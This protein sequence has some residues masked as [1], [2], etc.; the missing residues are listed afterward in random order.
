MIE[1]KGRSTDVEYNIKAFGRCFNE[2]ESLPV[3]SSVWFFSFPVAF[4]LWSPSPS[5]FGFLNEES[6]TITCLFFLWTEDE[7]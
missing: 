4:G 5:P 2:V 7:G 1:K 6:S 3:T